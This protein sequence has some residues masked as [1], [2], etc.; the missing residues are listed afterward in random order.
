LSFN[1]KQAGNGGG[2]ERIDQPVIEPGLY[3]ARLVQLIDMGLQPQKAFQGKDKPPM[4]EISLTYE[5]TD[6]FMKDADGNDL[7]DKPRWVSE[8]LPF[9][10]LKADKA[11]STQRYLAFDPKEEWEGDFT[12]ALGLPI[13]VVLVQNQV[14]DKVYT[15]VASLAAMRPKDAEKCEALK[16]PTTLFSLDEP[17][18]AVFNKFPKWIQEKIQKNLNYN[19]SRLEAMLKGG[20]PAAKEQK[21]QEDARSAQIVEDNPY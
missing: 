20:K 9:H 16:N 15:N 2:N 18:L 4:Q 7:E 19:G 11:K 3:P 1:A 13:N 6:V 5:L 14:G 12:K 10:N 8:T 17:D 21:E